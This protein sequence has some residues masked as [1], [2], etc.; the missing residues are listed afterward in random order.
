MITKL[1]RCVVYICP[2]C[3]KVKKFD[4]NIFNF[5]DKRAVYL[6]CGCGNSFIKIA[7][8]KNKNYVINAGCAACGEEHMFEISAKVFWGAPQIVF[9]CP[10]VDFDILYV[11]E[12]GEMDAL[13]AQISKSRSVFSGEYLFENPFL[14]D[15]L[16]EIDLCFKKK[17]VGCTCGSKKI[18]KNVFADHIDFVCENCSSRKT[19]DVSDSGSSAECIEQMR[20]NGIVICCDKGKKIR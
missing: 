16:K 13:C 10:N 5:S 6:K 18:C 8:A 12:K 11:G 20:S 3:G 2:A 19:L 4:I 14:S 7:P 9:G 15:V 17:R 1:E